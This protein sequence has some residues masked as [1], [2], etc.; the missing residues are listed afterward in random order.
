MLL[1]KKGALQDGKPQ[2]IVLLQPDFNNLNMF[3]GNYLLVR[4]EWYGLIDQQQLGIRKKPHSNKQ[5]G[6]KVLTFDI[7]M[8][9]HWK[10]IIISIDNLNVSN[11]ILYYWWKCITPQSMKLF[12]WIVLKHVIP[13][14]ITS[15]AT[16][17]SMGL[18]P[19]P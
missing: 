5:E 2:I 7:M 11:E 14:M 17:E 4:A 1:N 8:K 10:L 16:P 9:W 6:N 18:K 19:I 15:V 3:V 12:H 13:K